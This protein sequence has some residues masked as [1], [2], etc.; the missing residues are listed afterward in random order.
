MRFDMLQKIYNTGYLEYNLR[1]WTCVS[2]ETYSREYLQTL[3]LP[4]EINLMEPL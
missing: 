2:V 1:N 4:E 3:E